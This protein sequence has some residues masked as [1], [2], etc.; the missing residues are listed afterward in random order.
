MSQTKNLELNTNKILYTRYLIGKHI[1]FIYIIYIFQI[2]IDLIEKPVISC[3]TRSFAEHVVMRV[4]S[5]LNVQAIY[6]N[7][8]E[9]YTNSLR[10]FIVKDV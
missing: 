4:V 3:R 8:T 9:R 5:H 2:L 7:Q 6:G 1:H 10:S